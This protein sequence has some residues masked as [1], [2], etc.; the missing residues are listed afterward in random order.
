MTIRENSQGSLPR[1][2]GQRIV[3]RSA[4]NEV[5]VVVPRK[6]KPARVY[7]LDKYL[8]MKEQPKKHKPW[9]YRKTRPAPPDPLGA[10]EGSVL[11]PLT[12]EN[13]YR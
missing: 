12:R 3:A 8:K 11:V 4:N 7:S 10:V 5:A 2:V 13:I 9:S 1:G 6:G